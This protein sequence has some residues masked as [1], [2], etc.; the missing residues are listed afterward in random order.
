MITATKRSFLVLSLGTLSWIQPACSPTGDRVDDW[1]YRPIQEEEERTSAAKGMVPNAAYALAS[2]G[3][4]GLAVGG[5]KDVQNFRENLAHDLLPLPTDITYEGLFY[6]YH[7]DTGEVA[8]TEARFAPSYAIAVSR[9][10]ISRQVETYLSVGLNSGMD[11][12]EFAR[13]KLNL[14]V[15]LDISGSMGSAFDEY[16]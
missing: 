14:V 9:D 11:A 4:L 7:F 1:V 16:Y 13:K 5:A 12:G 6:D 3:S 10:P 8:P 15:V 2:Q